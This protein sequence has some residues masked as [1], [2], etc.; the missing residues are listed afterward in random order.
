MYNFNFR[1]FD[2]IKNIYKFRSYRNT[3]RVE[4]DKVIKLIQKHNPN[5][6]VIYSDD[7]VPYQLII[8]YIKSNMHNTKIM[9][10]EEGTA[11]YIES[12]KASI[13]L[14]IKHQIDKLVYGNKGV[15]L[16]HH[17]QNNNI[18]IVY[19]REPD[20]VNYENKNI[21]KI[22]I[23][24]TE[25]RNMIIYS[26]KEVLIEYKNSALFAPTTTTYN[27]KYMIEIYDKIFKYYNYNKKHL[28]VKLH[29]SEKYINE[30]ID[31]IKKYEKY[32]HYISDTSTTSDDYLINENIDT[33][34]SDYSSTMINACYLRDDIN[35]LTYMKF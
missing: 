6:V 1:G 7:L 28:Y 16:I 13:K 5:E 21:K 24:N 4:L 35:I 27:K 33:I 17:G 19:L 14:K 31:I 11:R 15:E 23:T 2:F 25:F 32:V 22:K 12:F 30:I 26:A 3:F 34:I 9:L 10:V 20:L 8:N 18:D 29:P